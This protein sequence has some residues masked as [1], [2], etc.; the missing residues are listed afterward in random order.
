[1]ETKKYFILAGVLALL[2]AGG[3]YYAFQETENSWTK[4]TSYCDS[5]KVQKGY[6]GEAICYEP[7]VNPYIKQKLVRL[8]E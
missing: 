7:P 2:V 5:I 6:E 1:M 8:N 4:T 3:F